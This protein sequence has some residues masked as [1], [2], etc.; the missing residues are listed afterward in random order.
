M[1]MQEIIRWNYQFKKDRGNFSQ[2]RKI[3]WGT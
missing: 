2:T 3:S 1:S